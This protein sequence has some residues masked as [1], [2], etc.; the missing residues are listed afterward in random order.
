VWHSRVPRRCTPQEFT[1]PRLPSGN[2]GVSHR[3]S[4]A[5]RRVTS[6]ARDG[7]LELRG[8]RCRLAAQDLG[9]NA[10]R[11]RRSRGPWRRPALTSEIARAGDRLIQ[12]RQGSFRDLFLWAIQTMVLENWSRLRQCPQCGRDFLKVRKSEL[13]LPCRERRSRRCGYLAGWAKDQAARISD[14]L[15]ST[16]WPAVV[17]A[18]NASV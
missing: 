12:G 5:Q 11:A 18:T 3:V 14:P 10:R 17:H 4:L 8:A 7:R 15:W 16:C 2:R 6:T 9:R 1:P 13:L